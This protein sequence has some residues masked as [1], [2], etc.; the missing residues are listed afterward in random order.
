M[1]YELYDKVI[2]AYKI[3][4]EEVEYINIWKCLILLKHAKSFKE[5]K[6]LSRNNVLQKYKSLL[7]LRIKELK[8][9]LE[10]R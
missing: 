9:S 3:M 1:I 8:K 6:K 2:E 7:L 10:Q 5:F 4:D